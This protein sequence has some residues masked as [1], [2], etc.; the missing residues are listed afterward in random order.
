MGQGGRYW[1]WVHPTMAVCPVH[2]LRYACSSSCCCFWQSWAQHPAAAFPGTNTH[3]RLFLTVLHLVLFYENR[4]QDHHLVIPSVLQGLRALVSSQAAAPGCASEQ[5]QGGAAPGCK[6]EQHVE[7]GPAG[8]A[9]PAWQHCPVSSVLLL[10]PLQRGGGEETALISCSMLVLGKDSLGK[11]SLATV[12]CS[13]DD[14]HLVLCRGMGRRGSCSWL[15]YRNRSSVM[16][17]T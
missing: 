10:C 17:V 6:V 14:R 12:G 9:A 15:L 7:Q 16:W 2:Q 11:D 8:L 5:H 3:R 4:L 13:T 1:K